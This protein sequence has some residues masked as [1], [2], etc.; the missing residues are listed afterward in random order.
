MLL[1]YGDSYEEQPAA[2]TPAWVPRSRVIAPPRR[3]WPEPEPQPEPERQIIRASMD[4]QLPMFE[5]EITATAST[6]PPTPITEI[7]LDSQEDGWTDERLLIAAALF[8][9]DED[10]DD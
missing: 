5:V 6:I 8:L 9:L 2:Q 3:V 4:C 7:D 1:D 10:E